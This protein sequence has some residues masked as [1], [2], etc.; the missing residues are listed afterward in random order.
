MSMVRAAALVTIISIFVNTS[1]SADPVMYKWMGQMSCGSW[2]KEKP[3]NEPLKA[4]PL[5]WV[6][7]Y[8]SSSASDA[9]VDLLVNVDQASIAAWIDGYCSQNPLNS[10]LDATVVLE[11]ELRARV[12]QKPAIKK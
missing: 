8:L 3:Y 11:A 2:P 6:L 7:G 5:N 10:I 12:P 4:V 1:A 9:H